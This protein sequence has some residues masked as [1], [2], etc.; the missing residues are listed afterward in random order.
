[1]SLSNFLVER[2]KRKAERGLIEKI[3]GKRAAGAYDTLSNIGRSKRVARSIKEK[4]SVKPVKIEKAEEFK[5]ITEERKAEAEK[6]KEKTSEKAVKNA[7]E[8]G[9][10]EELVRAEEEAEARGVNSAG[11]RVSKAK[12]V[13]GLIRDLEKKV[14]PPVKVMVGLVKGYK[15]K[16]LNTNEF[17]L[18]QKLNEDPM[19][20]KALDT[21]NALL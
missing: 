1:M 8:A 19:S 10:L 9:A 21:I 17:L 11:F 2:A 20:R 4:F 3:G 5:R 13:A 16:K 7:E 6:L 18:L 12:D 15:E 14:Y